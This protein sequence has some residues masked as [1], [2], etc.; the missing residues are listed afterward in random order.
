MGKIKQKLPLR[1]LYY[2]RFVYR[3]KGT[4]VIEFGERHLWTLMFE[5]CLLIIFNTNYGYGFL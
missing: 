1:R 3:E 4:R 2:E 5:G